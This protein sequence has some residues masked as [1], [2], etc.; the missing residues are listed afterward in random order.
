MSEGKR[1]YA[2]VDVTAHPKA[3]SGLEEVQLYLQGVVYKFLHPYF[4]SYRAGGCVI[5][6]TKSPGADSKKKVC[7]LKQGKAGAP[8]LN[9][10]SLKICPDRPEAVTSQFTTNY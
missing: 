9:W 5:G 1:K 10:D 2:P 3:A 6:S 4:E 7:S 8:A